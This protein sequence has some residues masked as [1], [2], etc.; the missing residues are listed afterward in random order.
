MHLGVE[1]QSVRGVPQVFFLRDKKM[2]DLFFFSGCEN[3]V[4]RIQHVFNG[5]LRGEI[6]DGR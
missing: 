1:G 5:F 3:D 6:H 4:N 2:V